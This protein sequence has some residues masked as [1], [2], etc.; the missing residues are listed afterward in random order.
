M[1]QALEVFAIMVGGWALISFLASLF[2]TMFAS[3]TLRAK[4]EVVAGLEVGGPLRLIYSEKDLFVAAAQDGRRFRDEVVDLAGGLPLEQWQV[5]ALIRLAAAS[6]QVKSISVDSGA[7][8][9][10]SRAIG[11]D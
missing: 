10:L 2:R 9:D 8:V 11:D 5:A 7:L 4:R 6:P 1:I 3:A